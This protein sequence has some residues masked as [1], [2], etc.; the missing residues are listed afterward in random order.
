LTRIKAGSFTDFGDLFDPEE[1]RMGVA[2]T[3]LAILEL[4]RESV[5]EVVQSDE[6]A[7][8]HVRAA[9]SVRLVSDD[10]IEDSLT[11]PPQT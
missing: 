8:L 3:F 9:S 4:L 11:E 7:P 5:I 6:F 1:G 2:V 10:D